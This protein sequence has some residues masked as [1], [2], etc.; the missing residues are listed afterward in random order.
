MVSPVLLA[1]PIT[2]CQEAHAQLVPLVPPHLLIQLTHL[3]ASPVRMKTVSDVVQAT[4]LE[5]VPFVRII[6][7]PLQVFARIAL[8]PTVSLVLELQLEHVF[9]AQLTIT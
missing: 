9:L 3:H 1:R 8:I 6:N 2:I 4:L 7:S 5:S